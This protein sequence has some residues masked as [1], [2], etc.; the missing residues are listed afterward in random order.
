MDTSGGTGSGGGSGGGAAS[1]PSAAAA[2]GGA[3]S[4]A[5]GG[6]PAPMAI[7][8]GGGAGVVGTPDAP[9]LFTNPTT[10]EEHR[11][12]PEAVFFEDV[13]AVGAAH[14]AAP[15]IAALDQLLAK[16]KFWEG[17]FQRRRAALSTKIPDV[18]RAVDVIQALQA[19]AERAPGLTTCLTHQTPCPGP[20]HRPAPSSTLSSP[21]PPRCA[22]QS[23]APA[24][25]PARWSRPPP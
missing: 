24:P 9:L 14:G 17:R 10:E 12:I 6:T 21:A 20:P 11:G 15:T 16:Y 7:A 5:S 19:A 4:G 22:S 3:S 8:T 25:A 23:P 2:G 13:P 18:T 1:A